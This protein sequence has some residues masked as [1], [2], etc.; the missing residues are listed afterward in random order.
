MYILKGAYN[1]FDKMNSPNANKN[2]PKLLHIEG[3]IW[4]YAK[5]Y[6]NDMS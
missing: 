2:T 6:P 3:Q 4:K 1:L 5:H